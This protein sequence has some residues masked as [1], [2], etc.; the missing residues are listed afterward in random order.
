MLHLPSRFISENYLVIIVNRLDKQVLPPNLL[1]G[2]KVNNNIN[3]A[4]YK[5]FG[6]LPANL[7]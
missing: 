6:S 1:Y 5:F 2:Q 4:V 3:Q 7:L